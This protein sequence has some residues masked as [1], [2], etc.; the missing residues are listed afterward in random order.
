MPKA[1]S[2][3]RFSTPEQMKG[4][5]FRRQ[6]TKA[7]EYASTHGLDLDDTLTFQDLG[8]SAFRGK[9]AEAG[10]LQ[11]SYSRARLSPW[12]DRRGWPEEGSSRLFILGT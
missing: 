7:Q 5:S 1:Y 4:D 3:L 12:G 9:N 8:V 6:S 10:Q 11:V 2:Y